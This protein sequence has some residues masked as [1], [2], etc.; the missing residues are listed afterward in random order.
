[1]RNERGTEDYFG[2]CYAPLQGKVKAEQF[3]YNFCRVC[4]NLECVRAGWAESNWVERM[5]TQV[6]RLLDNPNYADPRDPR[7]NRVREHDFPNLLQEAIRIEIVNQKNDWSI[8]TQQDVQEMLHRK[9]QP[10]QGDVEL[11]EPKVQPKNESSEIE[12][13]T[14]S[15]QIS[16]TQ[17]P[18]SA[19]LQNPSENL[20]LDRGFTD[21]NNS[22]IPKTQV[23]SLKQ[24]P[25]NPFINTPFPT[26]GLMAD[27][28]SP[29]VSEPKKVQ[30]SRFMGDEWTAPEMKEK[31]KNLVKKG[32][33]IQM[34]APKK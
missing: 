13:S 21:S 23:Q 31:P 2:E 28:S 15:T 12:S 6:D 18:S 11:V 26:S 25:Q 3:D 22:Q 30:P 4:K 17:K 27:G 14:T 16:P 9:N 24:E 5:S 8:P 10:I 7:F 1:M 19:P 33:R 34:G 20:E 32:A 29:S